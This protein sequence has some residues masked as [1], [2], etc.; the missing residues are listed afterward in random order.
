MKECGVQPNSLHSDECEDDEGVA[1]LEKLDD[2]I[3]ERSMEKWKKTRK[4]KHQ[5]KYREQELELKENTRE[6]LEE[7]DNS[8]DIERHEMDI[9]AE[10]MKILQAT[11]PTLR[12]VRIAIKGA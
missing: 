8:N 11:D 2:E 4:E 12:D 5:E 6:E 9:S 10:E 7:T 3:F 1:G